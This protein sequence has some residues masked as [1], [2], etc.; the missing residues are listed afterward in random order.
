MDRS[1]ESSA[2]PLRIL[3][4]DDETDFLHALRPLIEG[5]AGM[6]VV[7]E[8]RNGLDAIELADELLPD[9]IVIDVHMPLVDGVTAI[10]R[11]RKDHPDLYM[12]ALTGD[13]EGELHQAVSDAGADHVLLKDNLLETLVERL[14]AARFGQSAP[15]A[16]LH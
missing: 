1:D 15:G 5:R 12:I 2:A 14:A 10:A 13:P 16:G 3:I 4:A 6:T 11:L 8:A 9:A 7:G